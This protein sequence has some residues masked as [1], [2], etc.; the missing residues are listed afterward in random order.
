MSFD[1]VENF[2]G[3]NLKRPIES[4]VQIVLLSA[5]LQRAKSSLDLECYEHFQEIRRKIDLHREKLK[6]KIDNIA[7]A[8]IDKTKDIEASYLNGLKEKGF[9]VDEN[10]SKSKEEHKSDFGK[11]LIDQFK[12][13]EI[14]IEEIEE[15]QENQIFELKSKLNE[16]KQ[17]RQNL[18][19]NRFR[20]NLK[21]SPF[22]WFNIKEFTVDPFKSQIL[23]WNQ[24]TEFID[25]CEFEPNEKWTLL[26]RGTRD[27]FNSRDFHHKCDGFDRTVTIIES[28][29]TA[30]VFGGYTSLAWDSSNAYKCDPRAFLFS[31]NNKD[32][33]PCK[34]R[35]DPNCIDHAIYCGYNCGPVFG[36][37]HDIYLSN[38]PNRNMQSYSDFGR[39]YKH[40]R[41]V[42]GRNWTKS[43]LAGSF[44]FQISEI[45]VYARE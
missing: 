37:G 2:F 1:D 40:P 36:I 20:P 13:P 18:K 3:L 23:R 16:L 6:E 11:K 9:Q 32:N 22:G 8:L 34:I 10:H 29:Q 33:L 45:E 12:R 31:L 4:L 43:F 44:K 30:N 5:E 27:G 14:S 41:Y 15:E 19:A 42:K 25:L 26:Y 17:I 38:N 28:K 35:I 39:S 24:V 21:N 7:L